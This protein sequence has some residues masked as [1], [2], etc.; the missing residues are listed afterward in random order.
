MHVSIDRKVGTLHIKHQN[1][2]C[3]LGSDAFVFGQL[4][5]DFFCRKVAQVFER[6]LASLLQQLIE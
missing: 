4:L 6:Q 2:R 3:G 5:F 1:A